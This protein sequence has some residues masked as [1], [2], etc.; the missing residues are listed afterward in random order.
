V[1]DHKPD[2]VLGEISWAIEELFYYITES[3]NIKYRHLLNLPGN[4]LRVAAFDAMHTEEG[5]HYLGKYEDK[6][7]QQTFKSYQ[8]LCQ[9]VKNYR[10]SSLFF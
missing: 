7:A 1:K 6:T 4:S 3:A 8:E 10:S 2:L 9:S 5:T